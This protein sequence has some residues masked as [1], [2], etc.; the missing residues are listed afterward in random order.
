M[1]RR[2][3][4]A[5]FLIATASA[6]TIALWSIERLGNSPSHPIENVATALGERRLFEPRLTG[7]FS[8]G[9]CT[10]SPRCADFPAAGS[11][12]WDDLVGSLRRLEA[13]SGDGAQPFHYRGVASLLVSRNGQAV[14]ELREAARQ[15]PDDAQIRNDLATGLDVLAAEQGDPVLLIEALG[16]AEEAVR[17]DPALPEARFNRAL[18]LEHLYLI[19]QAFEAWDA[20]LR[21]DPDSPWADEARRHQA[22]LARQKRMGAPVTGVTLRQAALRED[23]AT[24]ATAARLAPQVVREATLEEILGEWGGRLTRGEATKAQESLKVARFLGA[25]L[26]QETGEPSVAQAVSIIDQVSARPELMLLAAGHRAYRDGQRHYREQRLAQALPQ[27]EK[28]REAFRD[29]GSPMLPLTIVSLAGIDVAASRFEPAVAKYQ[30]VWAAAQDSGS[31]SLAG[32][33]AWG[34]GQV[35]LRQG[36]LSQSLAWFQKAAAHL[37]KAREAENLGAVLAITAENLRFLGQEGAAWR[38]RLRAASQLALY[39]RSF[40]LHTLLWEAGWA[41][42]EAGM[43]R[44]GLNFLNE[45]VILDTRSGVRWQKAEALLWRSKIH[46]ALNQWDLAEKDLLA[47][48]EDNH[49]V[50]DPGVRTRLAADLDYVEG[51]VLRH[52]EPEA[53]LPYLSRA[54]SFYQQR[55][56]TLD[57]PDAYLASYQARFTTGQIPAAQRDLESALAVFERRGEDLKTSDLRVPAA[58]KVQRLYDEFILLQART[59]GDRAALEAVERARALAGPQPFGSL[60]EHLAAIPPDIAVLDYARVGDHLFIW[61]IHD[62]QAQSFRQSIPE[63]KLEKD[64]QTF[65]AALIRRQSVAFLQPQA[66]ALYQTLIPPA[67]ARLPKA[68]RLVVI[69]DKALNS[70]PFAA[71]R[72]PATGRYLIEDRVLQIATNLPSPKQRRPAGSGVSDVLLVAATEIDPNL[73]GDL[74]RL[75]GAEREIREIEPLYQAPWILTGKEA[76][77][78]KLLAALDGREIFHFAGHAVFNARQPDES[79]FLLAPDGEP[80]DAGILFLREIAARNLGRMRLVVLS[81]CTT[82]G[83]LDTRTGSASGLARPFLD[84]GAEAVI[85]TLWDVE[86]RDAARL[87]PEFHRQYRATGNA[88]AAL[89][90]AQLGILKSTE[91]SSRLPGAWAV[92][93][94]IE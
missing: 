62:G 16:A 38:Y 71:L 56:L 52:D 67:V 40:R 60:A 57:L 79:Y 87:L 70:L 59:G 8:Y 76:S 73:F 92:F 6:A 69:P 3:L 41:A 30:E 45:A 82:V 77:K 91:P 9:P 64:I 83:P 11:P 43:P 5:L 53:A 25:A 36:H 68:T 22:E 35:R 7:G 55:R 24:A 90:A 27:L 47:A 86:D 13:E 65:V 2:G 33:A 66:E 61:L 81:A 15:A 28:A 50:P 80:A 34:I 46:L 23:R 31:P 29:T 88:A 44:S 14:E 74:P 42:T 72:N 37:E 19:D 63:G 84:A 94:A 4:L 78:K 12:D 75:P 39:R 26:R 89:R 49:Q 32:R 21:L 20:Y 58:E 85:A 48:R 1:N 18:I 93:Q 51:E 10:G 17:L 54:V